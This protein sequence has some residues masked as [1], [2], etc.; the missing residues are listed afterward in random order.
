MGLK[1]VLSPWQF[2]AMD[3]IIRTETYTAEGEAKILKFI[4]G[5]IR[6]E[7]LRMHQ[8]PL[9]DGT[10]RYTLIAELGTPT[11]EAKCRVLFQGHVD[12]VSG[13]SMKDSSEGTLF[14]WREQSE[15]VD[16]WP[17]RHNM[18]VEGDHLLGNQSYDM[19]PGVMIQM[20][21]G[22]YHRPANGMHIDLAFLPDEESNSVGEKKLEEWIL[23]N[24]RKYD[25]CI[26]CEVEPRSDTDIDKRQRIVLGR[27][28][29]VK[30]GSE[31]QI[32]S[33]T[34]RHLSVGAESAIRRIGQFED[35]FNADKNMRSH[36]ILGDEEFTVSAVRADCRGEAT[37]PYKGQF[38]YT[39]NI[40]PPRQEIPEGFT[41]EE[42]INREV[43]RQRSMV[44]RVLVSMGCDPRVVDLKVFRD[45]GYKSY[46]PFYTEPSNQ[47]VEL[48]AE[49]AKQV[50]HK[51]TDVLF[52]G[53]RSNADSN[54][55]Y[56][57]FREFYKELGMEKP[58][59]VLDIPY[60]GSGAHSKFER[61]SIR[62]IATV[63][64]IIWRLL[65]NS[66]PEYYG[67][68]VKNQ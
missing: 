39:A 67:L 61:S 43:D 44:E 29:A 50:A 9:N 66:L 2:A 46:L 13:T 55:L 52:V 15:S 12:A 41:T 25:L 58:P 6:N 33:G 30:I 59:V 3:K 18:K 57:F 49:T 23:K 51:D 24:G 53:G 47:L 64:D 28:G 37:K 54:L 7:R 16:Q 22:K 31:I 42:I 36:P 63:R 32:S 20:D 19:G 1:D 10:G 45:K 56:W 62:S 8:I 68:E 5:E 34:Q 11:E 48:V 17:D 26:S 21:I 27:R 35:C 14:P 60:R 65:S 38:A 40:V 4:E